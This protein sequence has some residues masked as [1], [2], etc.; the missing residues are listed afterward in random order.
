M[1]VLQ[2]LVQPSHRWFYIRRSI[3]TRLHHNNG[4]IA[5]LYVLLILQILAHCHEH[6]E[7]LLGSI[8]Y[9][10]VRDSAPPLL[11]DRYY[12]ML[13]CIEEPVDPPVC[14]LVEKDIH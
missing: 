6:V 14:V 4:Q 11:C 7:L 10:A 2:F 8:Q 13:L 12:F 1:R 9:F 3:A 5:I